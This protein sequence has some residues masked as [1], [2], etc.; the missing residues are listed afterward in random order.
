MRGFIV[1]T[2]HAERIERRSGQSAF[3]QYRVV[4]GFENAYDAATFVQAQ[5][6]CAYRF[7]AS[8]FVGFQDAGCA[9]A[10]GITEPGRMSLERLAVRRQPPSCDEMFE[11][12]LQLSTSIFF[13]GFS[14]GGNFTGRSRK[15]GSWCASEVFGSLF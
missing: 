9:V 1:A 4:F 10:A 6:A 3:Q 14:A 12:V 7:I 5:E 15:A 13:F 2:L 11:T 8:R